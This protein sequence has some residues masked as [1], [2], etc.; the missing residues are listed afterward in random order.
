M[1]SIEEDHFD[2]L[3]DELLLFIFNKLLD[4]KSLTRCLLVSKRFASFIPQIDSVFLPLPRLVRNRKRKHG[5]PIKV[6]KI[7][8]SNLIIKPMQVL[9]KLMFNKPATNSNFD[10]F[11]YYSPK[12]VLKNFNGLKALHLE[13]PCLD[14]EM[15][16]NVGSCSLLK[17]KAEFGEEL[18]SCII[19][20]ATSFHRESLSSSST[21]GNE[22]DEE[23]QQQELQSFLDEDELK[24]RIIWTIS[25]LVSASVRH[26]LLKQIVAN[27]PML[28]SMVITDARK[29]G[30][31]CMGE[32][33]L[34]ELR[35]T[36]NSS[37]GTL[38]ESNSLERTPIP[39][40]SMNLRYVPEMQL[41]VSG[42]VMKEVTLV[43]IKPV[44]SGVEMGEGVSDGDL[45]VGDFDG[46]DEETM[47]F[48]EAVREMVKRKTSYVMEMSSF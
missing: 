27:F 6:F 28:Q 12:E 36:M 11:L 2:C 5:L 35:N 42:Y 46:E 34:V 39:N 18:K 23:V 13:L 10:H 38:E 43:V 33:Q 47:V 20:S 26:Y 16:F 22:G 7:L 21:Y 25:C 29:R 4:A 15:E 1:N 41:P 48:G 17:W 45:L 14:S 37:A 44:V 40:L 30:K 24:L 19:L 3:P 31:L 9:H 8:V 32:D